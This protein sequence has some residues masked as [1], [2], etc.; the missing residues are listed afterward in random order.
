MMDLLSNPAVVDMV[1]AY[2]PFLD[3]ASYFQKKWYLLLVP[4]SLGVAVAYKAVRTHDMKDYWRE[5]LVMTV[6]IVLGMIGLGISTYLVVQH[7]V[8]LVVPK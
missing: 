2:R 6:Q 1:L 3:P 8:P 7:V 5:V 4:L